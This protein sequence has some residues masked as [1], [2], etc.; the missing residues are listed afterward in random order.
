MLRYSCYIYLLLVFLPQTTL[1]GQLAVGVDSVRHVAYLQSVKQFGEFVDRFNQ[2]T[3]EVPDLNEE[4]R[5]I[6]DRKQSVLMLFYRHDPRFNRDALEYSEEYVETVLQFVEEVVEGKV[7]LGKHSDQIMAVATTQ[8]Y[9][10]GIPD[11]L[12]IVLNQEVEEPNLVRW[13][14]M[15]VEGVSLEVPERDTTYLRFLSPVSHELGFMGLKRALREPTAAINYVAKDFNYD[16]LSVFLHGILQGS[17]E[18]DEIICVDMEIPI[19]DRYLIKIGERAIR[20]SVLGLTI[21]DLKRFD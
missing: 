5:L 3:Y 4:K 1:N 17:I 10:N 12:R 20:E 7:Y 9:I 16:M 13:V 18:V 2:D 21:F 14:I 15:D 11:T 19:L 8:V 6:L